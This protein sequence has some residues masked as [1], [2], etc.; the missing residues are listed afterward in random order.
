MRFILET[1]C[2]LHSRCG[3]WGAGTVLFGLARKAKKFL[4]CH[5]CMVYCI[6][7]VSPGLHRVALQAMHD[8]NIELRSLE[9]N[10]DFNESFFPNLTR[11]CSRSRGRPGC[12]LRVRHTRL[13]AQSTLPS[14]VKTSRNKSSESNCNLKKKALGL[15]ETGKTILRHQGC[16]IQEPP[17]FDLQRLEA[18]CA[19]Q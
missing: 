6:R 19:P 3:F 12:I 2:F 13:T 8:N 9:S 15:S 16:Y 17:T 4:G 14:T 18:E 1:S 10:V 11:E 5:T 7:F